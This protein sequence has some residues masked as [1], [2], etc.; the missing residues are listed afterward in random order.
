MKKEKFIQNW[1]GLNMLLLI[2]FIG[3][4]SCTAQKSQSELMNS[5]ELR[6]NGQADSAKVLLLEMSQKYPEDAMVWFELSR[7]TEHLGLSNPRDMEKSIEASL[8]YINKANKI[9]EGNAKYLL[10]K[11]KF[12]TLEFYMNLKMGGGDEGVKLEDIEETYQKVFQLDDKLRLK[13]L[14]SG[15]AML[16]YQAV[17]AFH[18]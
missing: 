10:Y 18:Q 1:I 15:Q 2:V 9:E 3:G 13:T 4:Q 11:A 17:M 14:R 16:L 6:M 7:C 5:Y 8:S 12:Q